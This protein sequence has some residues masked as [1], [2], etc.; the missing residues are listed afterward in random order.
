MNIYTE[1]E[2][3]EI[4]FTDLVQV[5]DG[6]CLFP[7]SPPSMLTMEKEEEKEEEESLLLWLLNSGSR[8][9]NLFPWGGDLKYWREIM[10]QMQ[11]LLTMV[12]M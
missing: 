12:V 8:R 3:E 7:Q 10:I 1:V 11:Q 5:L 4:Q 6:L 9:K 2:S